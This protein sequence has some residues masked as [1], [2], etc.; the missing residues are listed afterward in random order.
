MFAAVRLQLGQL[1]VYDAVLF[2]KSTGYHP[3]TEYCMYCNDAFLERIKT[4]ITI[5]EFEPGPR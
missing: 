1:F 3:V 5:Q 2:R 4:V